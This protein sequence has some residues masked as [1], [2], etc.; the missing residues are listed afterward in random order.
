MAPCMC[1]TA[2]ARDTYC[3]L[4]SC[5]QGGAQGVAIS[6][7]AEGQPL[8]GESCLALARDLLVRQAHGIIPGT[9]LLPA[10]LHIAYLCEVLSF[11]ALAWCTAPEQL[12]V[13]GGQE[14]ACGRQSVA[15]YMH[16]VHATDILLRMATKIVFRRHRHGQGAARLCALDLGCN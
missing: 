2:L 1:S 6:T 3:E 5:K 15:A 13:S 14:A 4:H 8:L 16:A 11:L 9:T 12:V 10:G 7:D